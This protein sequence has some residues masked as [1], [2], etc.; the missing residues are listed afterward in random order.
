MIRIGFVGVPGSGKTSTARALASTC[1]RIDG[2]NN[3][4]LNSEYARRYIAKYGTIDNCWEQYRILKKQL[5][6]EESVGSPDILITD[7]PI[8]LSLVY[9][10]MLSDGSRKDVMI[11]N[12]LFS[13]MNKLN[14]PDP[15]YDIIFY[16]PPK[17]KPVDDGIRSADQFDDSWRNDAAEDIKGIFRLFKPAIFYTVDSV[18]LR[19]R[20][21]E[22]LTIIESINC[23]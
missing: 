18:G 6:W 7:S 1:R 12:D 19:E 10:T 23:S 5:E 22:C 14:N 3:I 4:E 9:A 15:R 21:E 20:V 16:L 2:L 8:F 13:E 11:V 17:L